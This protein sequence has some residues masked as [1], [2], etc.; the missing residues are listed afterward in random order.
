MPG[1]FN[2]ASLKSARVSRRVN[3]FQ[4]NRVVRAETRRART[5][6]TQK[7][8][9]ALANRLGQELSDLLAQ[10]LEAGSNPLLRCGDP[11]SDVWAPEILEEYAERTAKYTDKPEVFK[12]VVRSEVQRF[13]L[14]F[15]STGY[16]FIDLLLIILVLAR[17]ASAQFFMPDI[18]TPLRTLS[19][20][21]PTFSAKPGELSQWDLV[22]SR[23]Q[24]A[25]FL[26]G[27]LTLA[28]PVL[29]PVTG[30]LAAAASAC[31]TGASLAGTSHRFV[32]HATQPGSNY[33]MGALNAAKRVGAHVSGPLLKEVK[34]MLN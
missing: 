12:R 25:A 27:G 20:Y 30:P 5:I 24:N 8:N 17:T 11:T 16:R 23:C 3:R 7:I 26:S 21:T 19:N 4:R 6:Q 32:N 29:A 33:Q 13:K 15:P 2:K 14:R 18:Y 10:K 34:K 1:P 9:R 28:V 22:T 31:A